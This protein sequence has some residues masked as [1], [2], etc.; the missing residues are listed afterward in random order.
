MF[1]IKAFTM[2]EMLISLSIIG[3]IA[4]LTIPAVMHSTEKKANQALLKKALTKLDTIAEMAVTESQFQPFNCYYWE[5]KPENSNCHAV[6]QKDE[7]G[8]ITGWKHE[9][10]APGENPNGKFG[11]CE[12]FYNY[13]KNNLKTTKVCDSNAYEN[14][15]APNYKGRDTV[16][17]DKNPAPG[18]DATE[19]EKRKWEAEKSNSIVGCGGW[20][21]EN[22]KKKPAIVTSDGMIILPYAAT[23]PIYAIDVNGKKGPNRFGYDV[24]F[25]ILKGTDSTLPG[26][27]S[28]GCDYYEKGGITTYNMLNGVY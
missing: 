7:D 9:D 21:Y 14:G 5:V 25:L 27:T 24:F 28:G 12:A 4:S 17:E 15:C 19:E 26:F 11:N 2:A 18:E 22:M 6:E 23:I 3:V 20:S 13:V 16:F 8:K 10:C 1:K